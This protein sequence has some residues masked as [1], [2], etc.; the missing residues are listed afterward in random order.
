MLYVAVD[1]HSKQLT[2]NLRDES[3]DVLLRRQ[4]STEWERVR[5]F[6][7]EIRDRSVEAG[8]YVV[9]LEV[10]GFNEWLLAVLRESGC[11]EIVLVQANERS[12]TKTDRRDA[13]RLGELLWVNRHRLQAGERI[14]GLKRV[15]PPSSTDAADRQVTS[16]RQRLAAQRTRTINRVRHLLFK[17]NLAQECPTKGIQ[18]IKARKWLQTLSLPLMDRLE[19]TQLLQQW[20]LLEQQRAEVEQQIKERQHQSP[21]A[22]LLA[23]LPGASAYS[24][25]ALASRLGDASRFKTPGSLSHFWGLTPRCRNSGETKGRIGSITKEGSAM[26]RFILGQLVLHVLKRDLWMRNWYRGVKQRRGSKIARVAVM[27]RLTVAIWNMVRYHQP[28]CCGGPEMVRRQREQLELTSTP[29][30]P[31]QR[32]PSKTSI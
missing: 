30:P 11:R 3:G 8:G 27:R 28:Y 14:P 16:L 9:I 15:E 6:W 13:N 7:T 31:A 12:K 24:S 4:V 1:Q 21:Q 19:M 18:T 17:H 29:T 32:R 2:V 20:E 10:C 26:A 5:R 22:A 25:L 23:T